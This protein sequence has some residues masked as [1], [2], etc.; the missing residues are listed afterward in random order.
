MAET[1]GGCA[2]TPPSCPPRPS[3]DSDLG[4]VRKPMVRWLDPHQLLDTA[5]R[6]LLSGVF[7]SYADGRELQAMEPAEV[8]DRSGEADLW[9]DYVA[10]LGDGWNSTYTVAR[11][12]ATD[13]LKLDWD[14]RS[15]PLSGAGSWS[16][17]ATRCIRYPRPRSIE[18]H[19]RS[20]PGQ[21]CRAPRG[22]LLSCSLFREQR[23][24]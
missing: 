1:P 7:S 5:V 4:F 15:T 14:A 24:V 16:W 8:P 2:D 19:A 12:L 3:C 23:L 17:G 22:T 9:L 18:P 13:E 6:V 21:R 10:D 20:V 11:L